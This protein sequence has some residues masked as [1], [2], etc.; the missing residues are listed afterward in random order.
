ASAALMLAV[1]AGA[2]ALAAWKNA[3]N[4]SAAAGPGPAEPMEAVNVAIVEQREHRRSTVAIG[5][6]LALRSVMLRNEIAGT[7]DHVVL[8]PGAI[9]EAG[10]VLVALDVSVETAE[11]QAQQAQ[12]AL[13]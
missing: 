2:F 4:A 12:V 9:V 3:A 1:G 5:T 11:L 13:T 6:V 8:E 10:T 7:V